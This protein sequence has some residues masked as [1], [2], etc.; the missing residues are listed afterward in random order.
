VSG[1]L[2]CTNVFINWASFNSSYLSII[3]FIIV[4]YQLKEWVWLLGMSS[5]AIRASHIL[6]SSCGR[7]CLSGLRYAC[8]IVEHGRWQHSVHSFPR[9]TACNLNWL[10]PEVLEQVRSTAAYYTPLERIISPLALLVPVSFSKYLFEHIDY[11]LWSLTMG[12]INSLLGP[13][14]F[15]Y[16][17][18]LNGVPN[19]RPEVWSSNVDTCQGEIIWH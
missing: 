3:I 2:P 16:H 15:H 10:S 9:S 14:F 7:A 1:F 18:H 4:C 12:I 13:V 5:R 8:R 19:N 17:N 11:D 6:V